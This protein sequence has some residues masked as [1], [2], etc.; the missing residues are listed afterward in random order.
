MEVGIAALLAV[1]GCA[2]GQA[3]DWLWVDNIYGTHWLDTVGGT[4]LALGVAS[5]A[6]WVGANG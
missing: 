5:S 6:I 2:F 4:L 3:L 1:V